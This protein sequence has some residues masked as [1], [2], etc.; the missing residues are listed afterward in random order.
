MRTKAKHIF[1]AGSEIKL[2]KP[3]SVLCDLGLTMCGS[4]VLQ[5]FYQAFVSYLIILTLSGFEG[6][7]WTDDSV[8]EKCVQKVI[9]GYKEFRILYCSHI[10]LDLAGSSWCFESKP[11]R[12]LPP[13]P[14]PSCCGCT[15]LPCQ[16]T[17][18]PF[19]CTLSVSAGSFLPAGREQSLHCGQYPYL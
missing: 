18:Q 3:I 17:Q 1:D 15:S 2:I 11:H 10:F 19:L 4:S 9:V 7:D 14:Q 6:E 12:Q 13:V 8:M 16:Q 5:S